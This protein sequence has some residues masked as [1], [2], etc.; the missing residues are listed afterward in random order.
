MSLL[1]YFQ[2]PWRA[3]SAY[4][5]EADDL[6][7]RAA[8]QLVLGRADLQ[9]CHAVAEYQ[10]SQPTYKQYLCAI[11]GRSRTERGQPQ[12]G[13]GPTDR[14]RLFVLAQ[15]ISSATRISLLAAA[16]SI[17]L[18]GA[19]ERQEAISKDEC[20]VN[21]KLDHI[22]LRDSR[23]WRAFVE[24][25]ILEQ[26]LLVAVHHEPP[27]RSRVSSKCVCDRAFHIIMMD[28]I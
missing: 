3:K 8:E 2:V 25:G 16:A 9:G 28:V 10:A 21:V 27:D 24:G 22:Y 18:R 7:H 14:D 26:P 5:V 17:R 19:C 12:S 4:R 20:D 23:P 6:L 15:Q 1:I 11:F 13:A